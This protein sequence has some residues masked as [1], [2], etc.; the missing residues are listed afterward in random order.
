MTLFCS[1]CFASQAMQATR[2]HGA[3]VRVGLA[4]M[5]KKFSRMGQKSKLL[6]EYAGSANINIVIHM[7]E[8]GYL[9]SQSAGNIFMK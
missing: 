2:Q 7:E 8:G 4:V 1:A 6:K 5:V 9:C 3:F